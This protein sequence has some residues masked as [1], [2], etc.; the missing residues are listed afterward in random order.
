MRRR[1]PASATAAWRERYVSAC[2]V[3]APLGE[4]EH[5]WHAQTFCRAVSPKNKLLCRVW[6]RSFYVKG[7]RYQ[8][9]G[10]FGI[11]VLA[12]Y[13]MSHGSHFFMAK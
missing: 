9:A 4:V 3:R 1:A 5:I 7:Q 11:L 10:F 12:R 13:G 6:Q 2:S 8:F